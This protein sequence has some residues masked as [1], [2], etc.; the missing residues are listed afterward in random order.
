MIGVGGVEIALV[1]MPRL[2]TAHYRGYGGLE[3]LNGC[4]SH[5]AQ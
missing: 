1:D 2:R 3:I 4:D 5:L